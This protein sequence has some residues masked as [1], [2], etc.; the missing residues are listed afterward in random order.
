MRKYLQTT[1]QGV[2]IPKYKNNSYNFITK[3]T[4]QLKVGGGIER[5]SKKRYS[6]SPLSLQLFNI[7][8]SNL[9]NAVGQDEVIRLTKKK[10]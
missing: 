8:L 9:A 6:Y 3:K 1:Y 5:F 10:K 7:F 2:N 4:T